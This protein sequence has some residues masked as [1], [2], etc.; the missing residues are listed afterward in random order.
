M[1]NNLFNVKQ[2]LAKPSLH[3]R[4]LSSVQSSLCRTEKAKRMTIAYVL[5]ERQHDTG[6]RASFWN[7]VYNYIYILIIKR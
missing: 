1:L 3:S 5:I 7:P 6:E 2:F 4:F